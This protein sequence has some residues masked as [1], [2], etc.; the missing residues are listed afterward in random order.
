MAEKIKFS[1]MNH[2]LSKVVADFQELST[3][4]K[5]TALDGIIDACEAPELKYLSDRLEIFLKRDFV[6]F[7]PTEICIY[8]L[9]WLDPISLGRCCL[10]SKTW[11]EAVSACQPAWLKA[12]KTIGW[13]VDDSIMS[14]GY[15]KKTY[16]RAL[17]RLQQLKSGSAFKVLTLLGHTARVYT[18][19][20]NGNNLMASG[21]DDR[22]V[23]LWDVVT[24]ECLQIIQTHTCADLAF[25]EYF[26]YTA[27]FDNTIGCWEWSSG[28]MIRNY[29]GHTGA[30][31]SV[32]YDNERELLVSG[33]ADKTVRLWQLSTGEQ[34]NMYHGHREWV[35]KVILRKS[36]VDS[37]HHKPGDY[38]IL[39]MD[40]VE[41]RIWLISEE[42]NCQSLCELSATDCSDKLLSNSM[43]SYPTTPL[44]TDDN[45]EHCFLHPQLL[46]DGTRIM[47]SSE[48]GVLE[49][50]FKDYTLTRVTPHQNDPS[51]LLGAGK[52]MFF[53]ADTRENCLFIRVLDST[54]ESQHPNLLNRKKL[55]LENNPSVS[56]PSPS[57]ETVDYEVE[58]EPCKACCSSSL[59]EQSLKLPKFSTKLSLEV[60]ET[61]NTDDSAR[62][63]GI[64]NSSSTVE[65][66]LINDINYNSIKLPKSKTD[67]HIPTVISNNITPDD[68]GTFQLQ[69]NVGTESLPGVLGRW[70]LPMCRWSK[71]GSNYVCGDQ[72]WLNGFSD[73]NHSGLVFAA[74]LPDHSIYLLQW[75]DCS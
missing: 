54:T 61:P 4:D 40:K 17:I 11:N 41:I 57:P 14:G 22:S 38:V 56:H 64:P 12:C 63:H 25:D 13:K 30:V 58:S 29:R 51:F 43:P 45:N 71:R 75:S 37:L 20:Y 55:V 18:L 26:V 2:W 10:V 62:H 48:R 23:R 65:D 28:D 36:E 8:L 60:T 35:T 44:N 50:D 73:A 9:S 39:S 74:A 67:S 7:L 69:Q 3:E 66:E 27:S 6:R 53:A 15:W 31:F 68:G 21:S 47:C 16:Q 32:S 72:S 70:N 59:P 34:I 42:V 24:G 49:W 1:K 46:F 33:S 19:R 5:I 52:T